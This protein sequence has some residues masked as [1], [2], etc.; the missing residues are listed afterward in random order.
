MIE[1][2]GT[3]Q[4]KDEP[5][6]DY[7][8]RWRSLSLDC[9][10]RLSEISAV[11]MCIQGMHWGLLYIL[12]GIKPRTFEELATRAHDME[13]SIAS[14]GKASP[15]ADLTKEKKEFKKGM[16]S[17]IQTKESMAVKATSVKVTTKSKLKEE[18]APSQYPK[19]E[20]RSPTLNELEAKV[21]P[22][23]D[24]DVPMIIDELL[25][26]KVIDLPESKRPEEINKVGDPR[27]CKFHRVLGHPTTE[28]NHASVAPNQKKCSRS[29]FLQFGSLTPIEVDFPRKTLE[30]SL[31]IDNH[32]E[33]EVDGWTLVTHKKRR[34]Q[35]VFRI[36]LPKTRATMSDVNQLQPSKSVKPCTS[37]KINGSSS[38]KVRRPITLDEFF[39]EKF[40]CG[41]QIGAT[42]VISSTDETKGRSIREQH[43]N[44]I[45][46]DGGSAVNIMPKVV[47]KKLG[48]SIDELSKCN[49][50]IQ[51]FNQGGQRSIG[52][53]RV[54]L[55]IGDVKSNTL[56]HII[57]A[58]TSYNLLLGRPW[59]H[60]NGVVPSTLH[61]CMK[62]M[63]D[64]E[65]VKIDA[66]INPF[67][68]TESYFADAKF[69]LD[70]GKSNM[71]KHAEA[72]SIDLED[73]KVQWAAIKISKKRTEEVSIN[74]SPSKGDM[75]ANVDDEQPIFRYIPRERRKK[76]Q[77]LLQECTQKVHPPRKELSHITFQDLK[78][79]MIFPV[80]Q[81][82]SFTLEPSKGNTQV[83][84]IKGNFD[85]K[86]FTLF[87]KSGYNFSNLA[88]LGELTE[89]VTGEKIHGLTKSQMRLREKGYYVAT[90]KF[91]LGFSLPEPLR[92]S[93]KKGKEITSSHY[94]SIE[95]TKESKEGKTPQRA[96]VFER[97]GRLT[98]R[99]STFERLSCKDEIGSSKQ[100]DEYA[101]TSKTSV[102]HRLRT[103]RN[104]LSEI[105]LLEHENQDSCDITDDKEIHS[106]FPSRMK[107]K[108]VLSITT[109]GSLK[110]KRSTIVVTNQFHGETNKE[111]DE[112]IIVESQ[113][114]D[115]NLTE[116]SYHI[117]MEEGPDIDD[118]D[119]DV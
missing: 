106:V 45:L 40:F 31:E 118:T 47:L 88:K 13:L 119:D 110:V 43:L 104:S 48:I 97:I 37:Q 112:T 51:G 16:T 113:I 67:T 100:V 94:T 2:T 57:D 77:P 111:E 41:S 55:S 49:L 19:E 115:S 71:E 25:A 34:H 83:G 29:T 33:N 17:K 72:D 81:V 93:S 52:K 38:Q 87:E 11:E 56:I 66:D 61:Q 65:V 53:I 108:T 103:K 12:Q 107:R 60:E 82:P 78:E 68:E 79:K 28:A 62:Y 24:S 30:G 73:S 46:I 101:T 35:A 117:T 90:P 39:P 23:P 22:F 3:K 114:E 64:G 102:F 26:K 91:G 89:E 20:R 6:V 85:Q 84:Q 44:R 18:E 116:S 54:G 59:V 4:R 36:R 14:H 76:G 9:K 42:H 27:Y 15:F 1:L 69:Y 58:K 70:S 96:S 105:R 5:V 86:V 98:S 92:I 74:L 50:T 32:K 80:A 109:D 8:N 95:K 21:Y 99:V 63:K 75:Q 10:D 7:I